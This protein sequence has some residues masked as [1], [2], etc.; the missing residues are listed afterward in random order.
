VTDHDLCP[1]PERGTNQDSFV[2]PAFK[3]GNRMAEFLSQ[4]E[5]GVGL[6]VILWFQSWRTPVIQ[7]FFT[8][9]T[10][11]GTATFFVLVFPI[12]YWCYD[13]AIGRRVIAIS[14]FSVWFNQWLKEWWQR[15]RPA[16]VSPEIIPAAEAH[17]FGIPSGH[18]MVSTV[19]WGALAWYIRRWWV[20]VFVVIF[21]ALVAVSR[22]VLGVHFPQ[23]I[24]VGFILG[25]L[26][27][28][29]YVWLEPRLS[30]WFSKQGVWP[31]IGWVAGT[32][33][34]LLLIFPLIFPDNSGTGTLI[35]VVPVSVWFG[36]G[37]GFV[38]ETHY[39][40]FDAG[41]IWWKRVLRYLLGLVVVFILFLGLDSA[42]DRMTPE[43]LFA[44]IQFA[45]IGFWVGYGAPWLFVKTA[46][47]EQQAA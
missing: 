17:D 23:D 3:E 14:L 10:S 44:F 25:L 2:I 32:S 5:N 38:L 4:L 35:A 36:V 20:T 1:L 40:Q 30:G 29:V 27:L 16:M 6:E 31:Q 22:M 28:A 34:L 24:V 47:V 37:I 12:I 13:T 21:V 45:L 43:Y 46:L 11:T 8:A 7:T 19:F 42:F 33:V 9:I 39:L 15:P 41:G 26:V 18:T